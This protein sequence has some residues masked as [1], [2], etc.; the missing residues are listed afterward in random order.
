MIGFTDFLRMSSA[1][2]YE[3]KDE[4][5]RDILKQDF[6]TPGGLK[7]RTLADKRGC[8]HACMHECIY[9]YIVIDLHAHILKYDMYTYHVIVCGRWL[10]ACM[11][12]CMIILYYVYTCTR[13]HEMIYIHYY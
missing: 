1:S 13:M 8:M 5:V 7:V 2:F 9:T 3:I 6:Y 12:T 10:M 11:H 4:Q